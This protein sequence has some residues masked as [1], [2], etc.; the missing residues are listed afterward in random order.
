MEANGRGSLLARILRRVGFSV[1]A[2]FVLA[3]GLLISFAAWRLTE[4][5]VAAEAESKFQ[6]EVAQA[7]GALDRR[8]Q[9]NV[10]LLVGLRG[11]FVASDRVD[12]DDFQRYLSGFNI[13]Q[14]YA[15]VR[16]VSYVQ[17]VPG[18]DKTRFEESVR[19]D[20]SIDPRGYPEFAIKPPGAR[21]EYMVVTYIEP[22][23]GNERAL[24]FDL[25]S[26]LPRRPSVERTRDSGQATASEPIW[27]AADPLK[28]I[29]LALRMPVY[30]RGMPAATVAQRRAAFIGVVSSA[31]NV[32]DLVGGL[33]GRQL[34][35][36]FDLT[37]HDLGFS[38]E[39]AQLA[40]PVRDNLVFD[41][42]RTFGRSAA[43][44]GA[45]TAMSQL[46]TLDVAGRIWRLAFSAPTA[47]AHGAGGVLPQVILMGGLVTS[48][49][50]FWVVWALLLSRERALKLAEHASAVRAAEWLR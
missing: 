5:R 43:P 41:S 36:D 26:E 10:N 50:L 42:S 17:Y 45:G 16:L 47:P 8:F 23:A 1:P 7:V 4:Q 11:L 32:E 49:L 25:F 21:G 20:R 9:D 13:R 14:R 48:L 6:H 22:L 12:R 2:L 34:G 39:D 28:Q 31:I 46:M 38:G 18:S 40:E 33:L 30:R 37:I 19:R 15:G 27:L 24:G 29:S 44:D 35:R 3:L